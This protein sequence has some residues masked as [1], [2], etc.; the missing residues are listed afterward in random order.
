MIFT[1][2]TFPRKRRS[3]IE[4]HFSII[5][6][7]S[8]MIVPFLKLQLQW[9][10]PSKGVCSQRHIRFDVGGKLM[11]PLFSSYMWAPP[12][13]PP[14]SEIVSCLPGLWRGKVRIFISYPKVELILNLCFLIVISVKTTHRFVGNFYTYLGNAAWKP[15]CW[16]CHRASQSYSVAYGSNNKYCWNAFSKIPVSLRHSR[17]SFQASWM[18]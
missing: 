6:K 8:K 11:W 1:V 10:K 13:V 15:K 4:I 14:V 17:S 5:F 7:F 2:E 16:K 9:G 3:Q 18:V 12:L